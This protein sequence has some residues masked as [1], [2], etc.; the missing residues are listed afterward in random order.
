MDGLLSDNP[1]FPSPEIKA[2]VELG[3]LNAILNRQPYRADLPDWAER[4][5]R[6]MLASENVDFKMALGN[7]LVFYYLWVGDFS[8]ANFV[9][10]SMQGAVRIERCAPLTKQTWHAMKAMYSWTAADWPACKLAISKGLRN[11][12]D[13]GVHM[14]DIYL[15]AQGIY[16]GLSLG[17][18]A[19]ANSCFEKMSLINNRR[20]GDKALYHYQASS[21]AWFH[22]DLKKSI[23]HGRQAV[24]ICED[25]TWPLALTLCLNEL[26]VTLFDD[27]QYDEA[28]YCLAKAMEVGH[29]MIFQEFQAYLNGAR[30]AFDRKREKQGLELLEQ[31]L[32]LGAQ[33]NILNI[34]RW[35]NDR[36][37]RL[38]AKALEHGIETEYVK[39]LIRKRNLLP[40]RPVENWPYPIKI[41]TLGRFEIVKDDKPVEFSGKVQK[42]PLEMLKAIIA[43]G[44]E[45]VPEEKISDV[46]WPDAEGDMAHS[47]FKSN[48]HRLRQLIENDNA[49]T[50]K[51]GRVTLDSRYC[52]VDVRAF[53]HIVTE[54]VEGIQKGKGS[55]RLRRITEKAAGMYSGDFLANEKGLLW[56]VSMR[57]R[58]KGDFVRLI[59]MLGQNY[60]KAGEFK[61]A[62]DIYIRK[63]L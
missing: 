35:N 8:R 1:Q 63:A 61:K 7:Q 53:Q 12:E 14:L 32:A 33:H 18:P 47:T 38:S 62:I 17:D 21:V 46:L 9:I 42:K 29:G 19:M 41:Y 5:E 51:E 45:D 11:A 28:D 56:A 24:K 55:D 50:I 3:M 58:H 52:W 43:F 13:S 57:E 22:G 37:S 39:M 23:A 27:G 44:G 54:V 48:M 40:E 34:P 4:V 59:D 20:L 36:M 6:V 31:G 26:A 15:L 25:L 60:I 2:R 16:G 10:A 30:F 49:L